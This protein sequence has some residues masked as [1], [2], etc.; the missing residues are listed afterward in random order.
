MKVLRFFPA[1]V[2]TLALRSPPPTVAEVVQLGKGSYRTDLP[3]DSD[4]KPR[5]SVKASPLISDRFEGPVSTSDWWSSLVWPMHS[6]YSMP[7][8][9]HPL[10]MQARAD[11]L[12]LGYASEPVIKD[13]LKDGKAIQRGSDYRYPYRESLIAGLDGM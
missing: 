8:F 10:S 11:G 9:A 3:V 4:G 12:G 2:L 6:P 13:H 5:R 1:F 7:M